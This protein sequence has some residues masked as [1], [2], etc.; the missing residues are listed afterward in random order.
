M[1][2]KNNSFLNDLQAFFIAV[3]WWVGA[4]VVVATYLGTLYLLPMFL[5]IPHNNG[6]AAA[7]TLNKTGH[8]ILD[9]LPSM[10]APWFA[11]LVFFV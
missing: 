11:G 9:P 8:Q 6:T 10:L 5:P 2:R 3:P 7:E 4:I 1:A